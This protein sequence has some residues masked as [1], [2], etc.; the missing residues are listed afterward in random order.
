MSLKLF[1][2][3]Y[4]TLQGR[5]PAYPGWHFLPLL[6]YSTNPALPLAPGRGRL[7]FLLGAFVHPPRGTVLLLDSFWAHSYVFF[8]SVDITSENISCSQR[9]RSGVRAFCI[10]TAP[11]FFSAMC[12]KYLLHYCNWSV[13]LLLDCKIND[14]FTLSFLGLTQD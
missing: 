12:C 13:H 11:L 2:L 8:S 5:T 1:S 4:K 14:Y 3:A 9:P 10:F 6:L 7:F